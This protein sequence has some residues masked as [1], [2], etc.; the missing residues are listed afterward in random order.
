MGIAL[1]TAR[2]YGKILFRVLA[3]VIASNVNGCVGSGK[4]I[5][6]FDSIFHY[7]FNELGKT[8]ENLEEQED[9][10]LLDDRTN[11]GGKFDQNW[12][13]ILKR[14]DRSIGKIKKRKV[15]RAM[16]TFRK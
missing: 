4:T 7:Y 3:H 5:P 12:L 11:E 15:K 6:I 10:A 8:V 13:D 9:N 2:N 14:M 16:R 1:R